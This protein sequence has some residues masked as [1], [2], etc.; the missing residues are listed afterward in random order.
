[1]RTLLIIS[2]ALCLAGLVGCSR[3][4]EDGNYAEVSADDPKMNVAIANAKATVNEFVLAF[5]AQKPGTDK[6]CVKKP[7]R[8]PG[9]GVE[10]MWIDV[11]N[12]HAGVLEGVV[13]SEAEDTREVEM[14]QAVTLN[15]SEISDW[16]YL[17]GKKLVG[18]Y[19]IR[20]FVNKMSPKEREEFFKEND[21]EL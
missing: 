15:I 17:D 9:G 16:S 2:L 12:E 3:S 13:E 20:Y 11:T 19:T 5:H 4:K 10:H 1:M 14:G 18:G 21:I 6:F 8:T 7:Y